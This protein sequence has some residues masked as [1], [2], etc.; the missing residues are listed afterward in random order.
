LCFLPAS[1]PDAAAWGRTDLTWRGDRCDWHVG[2]R[3]GANSCVSDGG[4][5]CGNVDS[6]TFVELS[7]LYAL[8]RFLMAGFE[9]NSATLAPTDSADSSG[10]ELGSRVYTPVVIGRYQMRIVG[11][12][13]DVWAGLG[14]GYGMIITNTTGE[15]PERR[16]TWSSWTAL[17]IP[18]GFTIRVWNGQEN[19]DLGIGLVMNLFYFD[20]GTQESCVGS[21]CHE[22]TVADD[23]NI[24]DLRQFGIALRYSF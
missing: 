2:V 14:V 18:V 15:T 12:G 20:G 11:T 5:T 4:A 3:A 21:D 6:E 23:K 22:E 17:K 24:I 9:I 10:T 13:V 16:V 1:V 7:A 8:N 19:G